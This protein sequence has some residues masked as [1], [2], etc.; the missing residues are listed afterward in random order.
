LAGANER[1]PASP[2]Q[3]EELRRLCVVLNLNDEAIAKAL[4]QRRVT[5]FEE[6]SAKQADNIIKH[7]AAAAAK[8]N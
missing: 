6:L 4:H 2:Q 7:L 8:S 3:V 1:Q 5:K